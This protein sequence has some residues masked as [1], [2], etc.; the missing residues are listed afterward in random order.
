M[1]CKR[2]SLG[3][4]GRDGIQTHQTDEGERDSLNTDHDILLTQTLMRW[5]ELKEHLR[6]SAQN[7]V[8]N[9]VNFNLSAMSRMRGPFKLIT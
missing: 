1:L 7:R 9:P 2:L 3:D 6:T 8:R 5:N 4:G